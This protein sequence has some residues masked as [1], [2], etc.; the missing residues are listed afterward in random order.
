M[1]AL[2]APSF[3]HVSETFIADHARRLAP[4]ATVLVSQD[5]R[6]SAGYGYPVLG[7]LQPNSRASGRSTRG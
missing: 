5:G 2:L 7:H 6:G 4:G 3:G 1:L